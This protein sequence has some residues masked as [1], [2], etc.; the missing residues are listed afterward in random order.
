MS[1]LPHLSGVNYESVVDGEGVRA[2]IFLSGCRH[3]C[4]GCQNPETWNPDFGEQPDA[5]SIAKIA[6]EINKRPFVSGLTLSG[7]DPMY[8]SSATFALLDKI[9]TLLEKRSRWSVWMYTGFTWEELLA[10]GDEFC[11]QLVDRVDVVVD[12]RFLIDQ[13][14][15]R[16]KFR[17]SR[18][19]RIID[20]KKSLA[21]G[22]VVLWQSKRHKWR[23]DH[24]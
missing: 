5:Q 23:N 24:D 8:D 1:Q 18:N 15:K 11:R 20:V 16:L 2:T 6:E 4:P 10:R 22:H 12:G 21:E 14:D 9:C 17:G 3:H 19:Q 13:A 7:G